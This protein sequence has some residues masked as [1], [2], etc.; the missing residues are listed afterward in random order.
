[1]IHL[2]IIVLICN[3]SIDLLLIYFFLIQIIESYI[4]FYFMI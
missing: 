1:M 2:V 3:W 4:Y